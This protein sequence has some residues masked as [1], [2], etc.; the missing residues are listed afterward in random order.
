MHLPRTLAATVFGLDD[1]GWSEL[2]FKDPNQVPPQIAPLMVEWARRFREHARAKGWPN[3]VLTPFD[4]PAKWHQYSSSLGMMYFIKP[5]F[6][7]QVKL[8]RQGYPEAQIY[9]SIH[10]Y[11]GGIEFLEDVD[12][13]CTNAVAENWN[14]PDE[15]RAAGKILWQYSGA[16]DKSLPAVP[17]YTF[18][19]YF[20]GH[21]S[22]GSL[23]WAYN[24]GNRFD[25]LD[26]SNWM[27]VWNT[28][29]DVIPMPFAEGLREAWDERRL[30][31]TIKHTAKEK[32]A[33]ISGFLAGLYEEFASSRGRVGR[34][35]LD[36]F[37]E[38]AKDDLVLETWHDKM[39]EKLL[40]L[41]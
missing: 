25:T 8:L 16:T 9:G 26:G 32:N 11:Y 7:Q 5:Q 41:Q 40:E 2:A 12:I 27:Y 18:G 31:E 39:V 15:V 24:W 33:D 36:D 35:T 38:K 4:E 29:F 21:D 1:R 20:A 13:Y 17:R 30:L 3:V 37:W 28:P 22:R 19:F 6:K 23:V 34:S 10:H 14:M